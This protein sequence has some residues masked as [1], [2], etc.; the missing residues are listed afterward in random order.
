MIHKACHLQVVLCLVREQNMSPP[1][2]KGTWA[3]G[4]SHRNDHESVCLS[5]R[6]LRCT[7]DRSS[8]ERE[9]VARQGAAPPSLGEGESG[10]SCPSES[11]LARELPHQSLPMASTPQG[12][13][14]AAGT[15]RRRF[16]RHTNTII[17]FKNLIRNQF[18][19]HVFK[20]LIRT[21]SGPRI[22]VVPVH[23]L[24]PLC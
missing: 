1:I 8:E 4:S 13:C 15:S 14:R 6:L 24:S 18:L 10:R 11:A 16:L 5:M 20:I 7:D 17:P 22:F 23:D 12:G 2:L 21:S 3:L 19:A 9:R